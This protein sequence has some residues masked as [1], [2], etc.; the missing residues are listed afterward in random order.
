MA[1]VEHVSGPTPTL[2]HVAG[3]GLDDPPRRQAGGGV[4]VALESDGV[5]HAPAG[6]V[7]RHP[8]VDAEHLGT[9]SGHERQQ[10]AGSHAEMDAGDPEG[11]QPG[12]DLGRGREHVSLVVGGIERPDPTVE[13]LDGGRARRD[14][15]PQ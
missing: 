6:L 4:E 5:A 2:E 13:E 1:E 9:G 10:F 11:P 14:L 8:P 15:G 12:E 7:E 3:E